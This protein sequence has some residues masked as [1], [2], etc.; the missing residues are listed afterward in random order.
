MKA[1]DS[2]SH[3]AIYDLIEAIGLPIGHQ[4]VIRSLFHQAHCYTN[5]KGANPAKIFFNSG[6][7]QGCPLS[8]T[9]FILVADVLL[10]MLSS[11]DG[12]EPRM[13]ADDTSLVSEN[14]I[15]CLPVVKKSF[16]VFKAYTGLELN[17]TKTA[18]IATGGRTDLRSALDNIG[19]N[20]LRISGK[21]KYLGTFMGHEVTLDD[22]FR[23]PFD[24]L[25][26]RIKL[27]N[28]IKHTHS[29]QNKVIIWNT[30]LITIFNYV[31][32]IY[33]IPTDYLDW[34]DTLCIQWLR[35]GKTM[36]V[37]HLAR[38]TRLAGLSTP[39]R[40]T[41][42]ANYSALAARA[43]TS[44]T[45]ANSTIWTLRSNAHRN[46][47]K[48]FLLLE[49]NVDPSSTTAA[50]Y[51]SNT[52]NSPAF[53]IYCTKEVKRKLTKISIPS[54]L[55]NSYLYNISK[56]PSWLPSYAR[57]T[58]LF[59]THN[60]L[61]TARRL[62]KHEACYLCGKGAD[63]IHHLWGDCSVVESAHRNF[64]LLLN[65]N[66]AFNFHNSICADGVLSTATVGAQLMLTDSTW[67]A[68][69]NSYHGLVKTPNAWVSWIVNNT[70]TRINASC[71]GFFNKNFD[72]NK[73]PLRER[74]T[75]GAQMGSSHCNSATSRVTA[76]F[77]ISS[78]LNQLPL[79][80]IYAFTDGS[81]NPNPGPAGAGIA[82]YERGIAN[83]PL[84]ASYAAAL[85]MGDNNT[86]ELYAAGMAYSY[87]QNNRYTGK[88][89]I[90]TDSTLTRGALEERWSAGKSNHELLHAV[91]AA[92]RAHPGNSVIKWVPGHSDIPQ[93]ELADRLAGAG[94][95]NSSNN[96]DITINYHESNFNFLSNFFPFH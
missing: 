55:H 89:Y 9:L 90:F 93:N 3:Q 61:F 83:D 76:N 81:A 69:N 88:F 54:P 32:N 95:D 5:F 59:I 91:R 62:R 7:K 66:S 12:I 31:F 60:A 92:R 44:T 78:Y 49:Y 79:G 87:I 8:P 39:L 96:N 73:V 15:P 20:Q 37:L 46:R 72:N 52:I 75:Y 36:K 10:D 94:S 23:P 84:I 16:N 33:A 34:V 57:S 50:A 35:K 27:F 4:N 64:W 58:H 29:I 25:K 43:V 11:I 40:D 70:I 86:G 18:I 21:E 24:K 38:P 47:A 67:R 80:T 82:I 77:V 68:L 48:E 56:A 74:I 85:G 22:I 13:F 63:D 2:I 14:I 26:D 17:I 71:A 41:T 6:V 53:A 19:W 42:I 1:F 65:T 51:Y 30:W 28:G 45:Y